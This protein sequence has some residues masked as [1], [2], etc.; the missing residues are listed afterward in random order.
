M[1]D[2]E[3]DAAGATDD[4]VHSHRPLCLRIKEGVAFT[5][6]INADDWVEWDWDRVPDAV[7]MKTAKDH[8]MLKRNMEEF[9]RE[10]ALA[11]VS[12]S[13]FHYRGQEEPKETRGRHTMESRALLLMLALMPTRKST[14]V[15]TKETSL[16]IL[17]SML[18][19]IMG[20]GSHSCTCTILGD[21][22]KYVCKELR[23]TN[24]VTNGLESVLQHHSESIEAWKT[25]RGK[26]W[27]SMKMAS[28]LDH[29]G[30][31]D[32]LFFLI[33][34]KCNPA[35]PPWQDFGLHLWPQ[36]LWMLGDALEQCGQRL[37]TR[38][39]ESV[40][41]L[42]SRKGHTRKIPVVNKLVLLNRVRK[43]KSHRG[44]V[45]ATHNDIVPAGADLVSSEPLL[46]CTEYLKLL[47]QKFS[48][49][50]TLQVSWD[51]STYAG[52]E[53]L[54]S[55]IFSIDCNCAGYLPIQYLMPVK[56][57]ELEEELRALAGIKKVTRVAGFAELRGLAHALAAVSAHLDLFK[58]PDEI[59][60]QPLKEYESRSLVGG[61]YIVTNTINNSA[62]SQVPETYSFREQPILVS[63][64]DQGAVNLGA[65]DYV[66]YHLKMTILCAYDRQH[67]TYNDLKSA[68][69]MAK[70]MKTFYG[71][72]LLFNIN[73]GPSQSKTWFH[74]K[75]AAL[76]KFLNEHSPNNNPFLHYFPMICSER[77]LVE[78]GS[79]AQ[80]QEVFSSM[81]ELRSC[82]V[83]GPI[84]KL[85]RWYSWFESD[86]FYKGQIWMTRMIM[87]Y[88]SN[89]EF[90][91]EKLDDVFVMPAGLSPKEELRQLKIK[92]GGWGLAPALVTKSSM[93]EKNIISEVAKPL[94]TLYTSFTRHVKTPDDVERNFIE[95]AKD[96]WK[97][98]LL[99]L[100]HNGFF[101]ID[102]LQ[103]VYTMDETDTAENIEKHSIFLIQLLSKRAKSLIG[104]HCKPPWRYCAIGEGT[105]ASFVN[106]GATMDFEWKILLEAEALAA[107]GVDLPLLKSLHF[108]QTSFARLHFLANEMDIMAGKSFEQSDAVYLSKV[109]SKHLGDTV[110]I[111]N[112]HQKVKDKMRAARHFQISRLN[113]WHSVLSCN[114][115]EGRGV[116]HLKVDDLAKAQA[117]RG[118]MLPV[119][120]ST[121]PNSLPMRK[122]Y[123]ELMKHKTQGD[124][125]N[126]PSTSQDS[127]FNE[128]ASLE[129]LL[130]FGNHVVP[131]EMDSCQTTCLVGKP[132]SLLAFQPT[133]TL[134]MTLAVGHFAFLGWHAEVVGTDQDGLVTVQLCRVQ[135]ALEWFFVKD[136]EDW[137]CI[138]TQ[139]KLLNNYGPV[140]FQQCGVPL[141]LLEARILEGLALTNKQCH[142]ILKHYNVQFGK[143]ERKR[144]LA[145]MCVFPSVLIVATFYFSKD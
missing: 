85:M 13:E 100:V 40:P 72:A 128:V 113:K 80:R 115:L 61:R 30:I 117:A 91:D 95:M 25:L 49:C 83:F 133:G 10:F 122:E 90:A 68:L 64:T 71:Y 24:G 58:V 111:E 76:L 45:M 14:K 79:A 42:K 124:V 132:G 12:F 66:T 69:R 103:K 70:L 145:P 94:W 99:M 4:Q 1:A 62:K 57:E 138:P 18:D 108:L 127:L 36:V 23:F 134:V 53:V 137:L 60:W 131:N 75:R 54:I 39:M 43:A 26:V 114:V 52:D 89:V 47:S 3:P 118:R 78:S 87:L 77:G 109:A 15:T 88:E 31:F 92:H 29:A 56:S 106:T 93:F 112:T 126:W 59:H 140:C 65:L 81:K 28:S 129:C 98:E 143:M 48:D 121:N 136:L 2:F 142:V 120:R 141:G 17:K 41:V 123:Q 110:C 5:G 51:P 8:L 125:F 44:L 96:G 63:I 9:R 21:D 37:A 144:Y 20:N 34:I 6:C 46:E 130:S 116:P 55:T 135:S 50:K 105:P 119:V 35:L 107:K 82:E 32:I 22:M 74:R 86:Q 7:E 38:E 33:Y 27:H 97:E 16:W 139:V 67:R 11:Q 84:A 101:D 73:Y 102:T 19:I 104:T